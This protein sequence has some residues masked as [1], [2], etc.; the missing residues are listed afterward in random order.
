MYKPRNYIN[1]II[2]IVETHVETH[3]Q[4]YII[5]AERER[6]REKERERE[7]E[8]EKERERKRE[9]ERELVPHT[10]V[11]THIVGIHME[12]YLF[13]SFFIYTIKDGI[14]GREKSDGCEL[15]V[16]YIY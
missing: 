13:R 10:F 6:A 2:S 5:Q 12:L 16:E 1:I 9:R 8:R 7:R 3:R 11:L 4:T 15:T 14:E